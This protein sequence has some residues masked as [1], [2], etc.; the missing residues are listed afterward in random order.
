V[1][2][3]YDDRAVPH[4]FAPTEA[5][6]IRALGYVVARDRLLQLE[7]QAR[8][9]AGRLTELLGPPVL[10]L[11]RETRSLGL[12]DAAE[13]V[14]AS[15]D[16]SGSGYR[17]L[18][19]YTDGINAWIDGLG[20]TD[21]PLEY[22]LLDR[23]P[24]RWEPI[25][26]IHLLHRMGLTLAFNDAEVV[27]QAAAEAVGDS[28]ADALFPVNSPIQE[29]IVPVEKRRTGGGRWSMVDGQRLIVGPAPGFFGL[30]TT[31][32]RLLT[33]D[34][35]LSTTSHASNNWAVSPQR[36]AN[37]HAL[38][39][40]DPHLQ[41]TLPS[42][43]YEAHLSVPN[44]LDVYGVTIPGIPAVIIGFN[45]D[46]AWSFTN[47]ESDVLDRYVETVDDE[48]HPTRYRLDGEWRPSRE[49]IEVYRDPD[50]KPLG[51]DT[52]RF[53]HR[54]PLTRLGARWVSMRWTV[55]EEPTDI[56]LFSRAARARSAAEWLDAM[57]EYRW[58]V[59]NMLVADRGGHIAI[60]ATGRLPIRPGDG[61]GN[62][63]QDGSRS[64]S[65]WIGNR[66]VADYPQ[67]VD[68]AQGFLA[69]A[70]QQPIDPRFDARYFGSDWYAPWRALR[71]NQLLRADSTVTV[72]AMI[73]W[74]TDPGSPRADALLPPFI[75]AAA[76]ATDD[77]TRRAGRL[78][79]EWDRRYTRDNRRAVLFEQ[80]LRELSRLLWDE[81]EGKALPSL[82][83]L[84]QL[85]ADSANRWWDDRR[86]EEIER[87]DALLR[88][89]LRLGYSHTVERYGPPDA[90]WRWDRIRHANIYHMMRI[91]ALSE[92]GIPIEGG[93]STINPSVGDG[94]DGASWRMVV[95]LGE[96]VRAWG[97]YPGGQSGNPA[98]SH[99]VDRLPSWRE[100]TLDTLRYPRTQE[101]LG[102]RVTSVLTLSPAT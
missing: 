20:S 85:M 99:Y 23:R 12:A 10:P 25:D 1:H 16:T 29:P 61:P 11:D 77:S 73:R 64:S 37:H 53:T 54:G 28:A 17:T 95:D 90:G 80:S 75:A 45:R 71:I 5:D 59:Q 62:R 94:E 52:L 27:R 89:A 92:L 83:A 97:T 18:T 3:V 81:L 58:P 69:S 84:A 36:S 49:R 47:G 98:S 82:A 60:R 63:L 38:L 30:P 68:P 48:E 66:K 46:V 79:A 6:A 41:L 102:S 74:Q 31:D 72:L 8:V 26:A 67:A 44:Q 55:I 43:W 15:M 19:A 40:G 7:V 22:H 100:G 101:E 86:T 9:G 50:G 76:N 42:I 78:L 51:T 91:P 21:L 34:Y 24:T 88:K 93:P 35:R 70:N 65:D 33:T 57:S 14:L 96:E 87:R 39:A 4:I 2:V 13:R 32:Q 56:G